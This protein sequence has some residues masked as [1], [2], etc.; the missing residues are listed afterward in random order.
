MV[1][2]KVDVE[3]LWVVMHLVFT[4]VQVTNGAKSSADMV[5][6][7]IVHTIPT[8]H[9]KASWHAG[10]VSNAWPNFHQKQISF[11]ARCRECQIV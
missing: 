4:D 11:T 8:L 5:L 9:K 3:V 10:Y 6:T 2:G 7:N 1:L